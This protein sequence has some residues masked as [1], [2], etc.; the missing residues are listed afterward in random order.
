MPIITLLTDFGL[1]D[2]YVGL[3]KGVILSITPE[4]SIV[5]ISH[6]IDPQDIV[7]AAYLIDSAYPY[8]PAKTV[9]AAVVDPGVG[10]SR[11]IIAAQA[12]GHYFLAPD[13]GILTKVLGNINVDKIIQVENPEYFMRPVSRT[14]HGR[15]IFAPV[16]AHLAAG[17]ALD[18]FGPM[19]SGADMV[20]LE[21]PV[22]C[23]TDTGQLRGEVITVD[24][25]GNLITNIDQHSVRRI[26]ATGDEKDL[27]VHVGS[28][29]IKGISTF[30][31]DVSP[32]ELLA[33]IG[34]RGY[35]EI[36]V[37]QGDAKSYC[38]VEKGASV[39]VTAL[40]GG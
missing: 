26:R 18:T 30:Y 9:H 28:R 32:G 17:K 19:I 36:S 22:S 33:L 13:N 21:L 24:R 2:P 7:S 1:S 4:A 3:M 5:D 20:R 31:Q 35:L 6:D 11:K 40:G 34:S 15:D 25:F 37:N 38:G 16:A 12:C 23:L 8:F 10:S 39:T 29:R 27:C 14:F